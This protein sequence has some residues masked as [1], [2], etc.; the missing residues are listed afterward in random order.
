MATGWDPQQYLKFAD[1]RLRPAIDLL[2]QVALSDPRHI[3][4]LGCGPGN[5]TQLLRARFPT[6]QVTGIDGSAA[7]LAQ[8]AREVEGCSWLQAD[9]ADWQAP[10][11][12]D[13]IYSNAALHWVADHERL[14]PRLLSQLAP[15]GLLAVQMPNNFAAPSHRLIAEAATSGPWRGT[16]EALLRPAPVHAPS[17]YYALLEPLAL[18]VSIWETEYLQT[19]RG[20]DP[21]KE[22]VKGSWLKP[23]LDALAQPERADFEAEVARRLRSAYPALPSGVTLFAFKRLFLIARRAP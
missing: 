13:L 16:L 17:L 18:Q 9:L 5:S 14:F 10:A 20:A 3:F 4:D 21:V 7:M 19:L 22:W 12:A 23:L 6:A 1:A 11:A 15:G 2:A 8:A